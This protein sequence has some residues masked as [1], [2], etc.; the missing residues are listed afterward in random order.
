M[1]PAS[2]IYSILLRQ[3]RIFLGI[4][5]AA[6][7]IPL[8]VS[9]QS[10]TWNGG[11]GD[12][13]WSTALNWGGTAPVA[14]DAL[15]FGGSVRPT[16]V[17]N[18]AADTSFNGITF[19]AGADPFTLSGNRISLGGNV[20]NNSTSIQTLSLALLLEATRSFNAATGNIT[21]SSI[22]SGAGGLIKTGTQT[23][24]LSG[25]AAN[26]YTGLT[27]VNAG[28]LRLDKTAGI[29]AV[30][31]NLEIT[32]GGMVTFGKNNQLNDTSLV[33]LSGAGS[34]FN[35]TGINVG[36]FSNIVETIG[37]I[38]ATGGI[39]NTSG[40][41]NWTI[42]GAGNFTGGSDN[43]VFLG[44]S[45]ARLS[46]GS[47]SITNMPATAG[48]TV[49]TANS[50]SLYGNST[51]LASIT[52]GAGGLTLDNSRLNLRRGGGTNAGSKLVLNGDITVIGMTG[53]II[54]EDTNGGTSGM[55]RMELSG[56]AD[57]VDRVINVGGN[58][59]S[60]TIN[61]EITNGASTLAGITK[62][63]EGTLTLSGIHAN[64]YTGTTRINGG[65]L[66]LNQ[67][68][69]VT[70]VAG[71]IIVN[72]GGTLTMAA[73]NQI[74][75]GAGITVDGGTIT[76]W[77]RTETIAF[78]T[79]NSGGLTASGNLGQVTILGALTLNGG[80][81]FTINSTTTVSVLEPHFQA[82]SVVMTGANILIGGNN[83]EGRNR[84]ALTIGSGGLNMS[85]QTITL[86]R[87]SSGTVINL[88]GNFTGSGTNTIVVS[89]TGSVEPELNLGTATRTFDVTGG[90]T[91]ISVGIVGT[92]GLTKTGAGTLTFDGAL[93][94]TYS[95][96]TTV[97]GGVL[98][99]AQT[100]GTNA[101]TG[102][103]DIATG[104]TLTFGANEQIADT[105]SITVNGGTI[106]AFTRIE[107][108]AS[109]TQN[110]GGFTGAG[111]TGSLIVTGIV[112]L[113]GGTTMTLNSASSTP[114]AWIFNEAVLT[115]A[116]ILIGGN[117][118]VGNPRSR[119]TIQSGGLTLAGRS[120][121]L[122]R[123][124]SA[125][126]ELYL[127]GDV[128]ATGTSAITTGGE[129]QIEPVLHLGTGSRTFQITSGTTTI[130]LTMMDA[131]SI[132][133]TGNGTLVMNTGSS[134]SGGT[135][136]SAGMLRI[137]NPTGSATGTGAFT[138]AS[139][140][141]LS[142]NGGIRPGA[143]QNILINGILSVGT[144]S[145]TVGETLT[146]NTTNLGALAI[147]SRVDIDLFSGQASGGLN[148]TETA[149]RLILGSQAGVTLGANSVL[150]VTTSIPIDAQNSAAWE[151]GTTWQIIDWTGITGG[152][153][154]SFS[155]LAG[156]STSNYADLPDLS[157]LGY[158]WD[159]SNLY[160]NGTI[161]VVVPEPSRLL[162]I[163][164]GVGMLLVRRR[165]SQV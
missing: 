44:N 11:G 121:T 88:N 25:S 133:K 32:S 84:T 100:A 101:I 123:A 29:N 89:N 62:T 86:Y 162:L 91:S 42:V 95:G 14:G 106:S 26:T 159:V 140:A 157:P 59:A 27:S 61:V 143:G 145:P 119:L 12:N 73:N 141:T 75:N 17:N 33:T 72:A 2:T 149:D 69:D 139:G 52:V 79:Q 165:R 137:T 9:A 30:A 68:A 124:T 70:A 154:G 39:F 41:G 120:I 114:P 103:L 81:I 97:S 43:T 67:T 98:N 94:N 55:V 113:N 74:D 71:N 142:G 87:G 28:I 36:M 80:N 8:S 48:G 99:L 147:N 65:T 34:V 118:G 22:I 144:P 77:N 111:N 90:T 138:L 21:V 66:I 53:S 49:G 31:G 130:G 161:M 82:G 134:Y 116:N 47:L 107:T 6:F 146:L 132:L 155:N 57:P 156:G 56:T 3:S 92:G 76:G 117:N 4:C 63:G 15:F 164:A 128:T 60:L 18:L 112:T 85:G 135:T 54:N 110:S 10:A 104:G 163:F 93:A 152:L 24:T 96:T 150:H 158:F 38:T 105:A 35:G 78:Y 83:G 122:N 7:S 108:I 50:F 153:T 40:N 136:I 45:G 64:S 109:Y 37:G 46:F 102:D 23:L 51:T 125:G 1:V 127:L 19:N 129:G 151:P 20:I 126:T 115:G 16:A 5:T 58:G 160:T 13:N 131:A 148:G